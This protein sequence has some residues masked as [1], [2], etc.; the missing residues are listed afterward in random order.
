MDIHI[1][2]NQFVV[3]IFLQHSISIPVAGVRLTA[4]EYLAP[5]SSESCFVAPHD[6]SFSNF[7][8]RPLNIYQAPKG[9]I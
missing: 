5:L 8:M 7:I 1:K 2:R 3:K 4:H 6:P 9:V